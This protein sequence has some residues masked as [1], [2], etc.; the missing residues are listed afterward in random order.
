MNSNQ[1]TTFGDIWRA[2]CAYCKKPKTIFDL[3]D[4]AKGLIILIIL[5]ILLQ[6]VVQ[7]LLNWY[8]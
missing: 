4:R 3:K 7:A 6:A 1:K 8:N 5:I 2:W